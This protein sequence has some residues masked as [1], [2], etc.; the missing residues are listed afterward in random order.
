GS[1]QEAEIR[2]FIE[3]VSRK[4]EIERTAADRDKE[5]I[6]TGAYCINPLSGEE[7]PIYL[8]DYVL[9]G[10]GTGAIMAVPA[11]DDRDLAFARKY[12]IPVRVVIQGDEELD[13][14]T[15]T[16]AFTDEGRM[17]NSGPFD[18]L[19]SAQAW[20]KIVDA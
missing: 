3:R 4:N 19:P 14:E 13:G 2:A 16:A 8:G 5:G 9:A 1:P 17:I 6:F 15:M 7:I 12:G 18:G 10:Y 11:H 20:E